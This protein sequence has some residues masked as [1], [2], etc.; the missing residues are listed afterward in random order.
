MSAPS[1]CDLGG[2][3]RLQRLAPLVDDLFGDRTGLDQGQRAVELA[4]GEFHLGA[5]IREL[6]VGL[7]G[8]R[9]ERAGIDRRKAGRRP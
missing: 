6:A 5:R 7:L 8:D 3:R 1:A 4:L 9:L 2:L